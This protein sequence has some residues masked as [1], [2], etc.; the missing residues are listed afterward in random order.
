MNKGKVFNYV[1]QFTND[2]AMATR[3][4]RH[5]FRDFKI[6]QKYRMLE[7]DDLKF[8][9]F[10]DVVMTSDFSKTRNLGSKSLEI[11]ERIKESLSNEMM[12]GAYI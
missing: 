4:S 11:I 1:R 9:Y 8:E 6:W 3:I 2:D 12:M 7:N 10:K 5:V